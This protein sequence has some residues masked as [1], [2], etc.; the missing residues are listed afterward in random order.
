MGGRRE[1]Y[2]VLGGEI[3]LPVLCRWHVVPALECGRERADARVAEQHGD[4][5]CLEASVAEVIDGQHRAHLVE[6]LLEARLFGAQTPLQCPAAQLQCA[7]GSI[8]IGL[9]SRQQFREQAF[10]LLGDIVLGIQRAQ[11]FFGLFYELTVHGGKMLPEF[12][13]RS[14]P[15]GAMESK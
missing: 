3:F 13:C 9:A 8:G 5:E 14:P 15:A 11:V 6:D 4:F 10:E 7:A 2:S 12:T 1:K